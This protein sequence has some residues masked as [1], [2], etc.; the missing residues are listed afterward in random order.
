MQ[1]CD[2]IICCVLLYCSK[3]LFNIAKETSIPF[4]QLPAL[5]RYIVRAYLKG[6][7]CAV[8]YAVRAQYNKF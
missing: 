5:C 4:N 3:L 6:V 8:T 1:M 2:I 7:P